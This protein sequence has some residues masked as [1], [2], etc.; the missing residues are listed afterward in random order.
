MDAKQQCP[1]IANLP[2]EAEELTPEE[3]EQVRGGSAPAVSEI[4]VTK[5]TDIA[6]TNF[7][8]NCC[9]GAHY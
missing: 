8:R 6:S 2:R 4:T 9:A 1:P 5:S 3:A 7:F